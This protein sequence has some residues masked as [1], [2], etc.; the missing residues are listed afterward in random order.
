MK[1]K[2]SLSRN[3]AKIKSLTSMSMTIKSQEMQAAHLML[4]II[5]QNLSLDSLEQ[6]SL[7][8]VSGLFSSNFQKP[9]EP[10]TSIGKVLARL[11][12]LSS[13]NSAWYSF[14]I[15]S[16]KLTNLSALNL[17]L[18]SKEVD[19]DSKDLLHFHHLPKL[20]KLTL[21]FLAR[22]F[23]S[24]INFFENFTL[25]SSLEDLSLTLTG[26]TLSL[27]N[28][29]DAVP[30]QFLNRLQEAKGVKALNL[31][32]AEKADNSAL[33][34]KFACLLI[35][36]FDSL[37]TL[38]FKNIKESSYVRKNN[39]EAEPKPKPLNFEEFWAAFTSSKETLQRISV[40]APEIVFPEDV[41]T[42]ETGFPRLQNLHLQESVSSATELGR[43]CRKISSLR[44]L[45]LRGVKF[46]DEQKLKTFLDDMK[47]IPKGRDFAL[48]LDVEGIEQ[49]LLIGC[50][51][52]YVEGVRIQGRLGI[53][54][55]GVQ[56][57]D[58]HAFGEVLK[59]VVEKGRFEPFRIVMKNSRQL[60]SVAKHCILKVEDGLI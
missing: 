15:S 6:G 50:L 22:S 1:H 47:E 27:I 49:E 10:K 52:K 39:T 41:N 43:F 31:T 56:A 16:G 12:H 37:E 55:T 8:F 53:H 18:P 30:C 32:I 25:P 42:L 57:E 28:E 4:E 17:K 29:N 19:C 38:E 11:T 48:Y 33:T 21:D 44:D 34:T 9:L 35:K 14:L 26:F 46:Q 60:F 58:K 45:S 2:A 20:Q 54:F 51:K 5:D 59:L 40:N 36:C 7:N 24:E 23:P 13:D 3:L